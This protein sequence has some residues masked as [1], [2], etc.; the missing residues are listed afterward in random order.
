MDLHSIQF[1][2]C[3]L[4]HFI[5]L[6]P[7]LPL[8]DSIELYILENYMNR[9][10]WFGD[11]RYLTVTFFSLRINKRRDFLQFVQFCSCFSPKYTELALLFFCSLLQNVQNYFSVHF[12]NLYSS[13][14]IIILILSPICTELTPILYSDNGHNLWY[15]KGFYAPKEKE[16]NLCCKHIDNNTKLC[17]DIYI[18]YYF[19]LIYFITTA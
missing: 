11:I 15:L 16:T 2:T 10:V 4:Y 13:D 18:V 9:T 3:S 8:Y 6:T 1:F 5:C 17:V 19:I 12:S 7:I 14:I